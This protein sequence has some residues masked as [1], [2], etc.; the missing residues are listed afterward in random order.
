[1]FVKKNISAV[2]V[3]V[4]VLLLATVPATCTVTVNVIQTLYC[5]LSKMYNY[6]NLMLRAVPGTW[7]LVRKNLKRRFRQMLFLRLLLLVKVAVTGTESVQ[8][9]NLYCTRSIF[10]VN[11]GFIKYSTL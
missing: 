8:Y 2:L 4:P 3:P 6:K 9:I 7:Y 1:M 11:E 5:V 10:L